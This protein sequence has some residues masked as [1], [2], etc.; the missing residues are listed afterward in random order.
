MD[1]AS[2][3]EMRTRGRRR[4][5]I[6][7]FGNSGWK[8]DSGGNRVALT[9]HEIFANFTSAIDRTRDS[10]DF[11]IH[12]WDRQNEDQL[13]VLFRPK[14]A[15]FEEQQ[16][17]P[18]ADSH[19]PPWT[20]ARMKTRLL[21]YL[22]SKDVARNIDQRSHT[23]SFRAYSRWFSTHQVIRLKR[24]YEIREGF[25]YDLVMLVRFDTLFPNGLNFDL[26][27]GSYFFCGDPS[28]LPRLQHNYLVST[29]TNYW[30]A[31]CGHVQTSRKDR[32]RRILRR[33]KSIFWVQ[34][35]W[36]SAVL[37]L[38]R[39]E[40]YTL[41]DL[42]F[43]SPSPMMDRFADLFCFIDKY[44]S[45]PHHAAYERVR[46]EFG[47]RTLRFPLDQGRDYEFVRSYPPCPVPTPS[48]A[49]MR[50]VVGLRK[51]L[52]CRFGKKGLL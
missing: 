21:Q 11:F 43:A 46:D 4:I 12:T 30:Y 37:S 2:T 39:L 34:P 23:E 3:N 52:G 26:F 50:N 6:C 1:P 27:D 17:F 8:V 41:S 31:R 22:R 45:N 29:S 35:Y 49:A 36:Y 25:T 14:A 7:F 19:R 16:K 13:H 24:Q 48:P 28:D 9:P 38:L 32:V 42:W 5:A 33:R 20:L 15:V 10:I 40:T 44:S 51:W 47:A 18:G